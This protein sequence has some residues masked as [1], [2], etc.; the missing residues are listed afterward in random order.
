MRGMSFEEWWET[1]RDPVIELNKDT[2][3]KIWDAAQREHH[4]DLERL[5]LAYKTLFPLANGLRDYL[6]E[7]VS[8]SAFVVG[9]GQWVFKAFCD[10]LDYIK[11]EVD[12]THQQFK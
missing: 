9:N 11:R 3:A 5:V 2:A 1:G 6:D 8:P 7:H 4:H 12:Q 10:E